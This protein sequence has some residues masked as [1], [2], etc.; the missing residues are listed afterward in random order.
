MTVISKAIRK[1]ET[2]QAVLEEYSK[3]IRYFG[4]EF[5]VY[6]APEAQIRLATTKQIAD[7]IVR[8]NRGDV[9]WVPGYDGVFGQLILDDDKQAEKSVDKKQTSLGDF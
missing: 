3:L 9:R 7:S 1:P 4:S 6:E 2:S 5:A 8:V